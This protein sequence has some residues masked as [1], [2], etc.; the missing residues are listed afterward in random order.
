MMWMAETLGYD[1]GPMEGFYEDQVRNVLGIPQ[2]VRVTFLLA[3]GRL[4][5][6]DGRNPGRLPAS[7]TVFADRYGERFDLEFASESP[8]S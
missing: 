7:R 4:R 5:G 6:R 2:H 1:T 3:I 8:S